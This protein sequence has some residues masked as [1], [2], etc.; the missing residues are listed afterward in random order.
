M[1][2]NR[3][4]AGY[5]RWLLLAAV[6]SLLLLVA[7]AFAEAA[8]EVYPDKASYYPNQDIYLII[9]GPGDS[10]FVV[11][12]LN[13]LGSVV[14]EKSGRTTSSG[15]SYLSYGGFSSE[16]SYEIRLIVDGNV[17]AVSSFIVAR[18]GAVIT[19]TSQQAI[20]TTTATTGTVTTITVTTSFISPTTPTT[21]VVTTGGGG[22]TSVPPNPTI[23]TLIDYNGLPAIVERVEVDGAEAIPARVTWG[24]LSIVDSPASI[25]KCAAG[26]CSL[27][28]GS[29][30]ARFIDSAGRQQN[31]TDVVDFGWRTDRFRLSWLNRSADISVFMVYNGVRYSVEEIRALF[32]SVR[33]NALVRDDTESYKYALNISGIPQELAGGLAYV[34]FELKPAA[35]MGQ[36]SMRAD[37]NGFIVLNDEL[38]LGFSDLL[39]SNYSVSFVN[40]STVLIGGVRNKTSLFLDP[41]IQLQT[42]G[43]RNLRDTWVWGNAVDT[44]YG[45][46]TTMLLQDRASRRGRIHI[47][48]NISAVPSSVSVRDARL[49]L[50]LSTDGN[51]LSGSAYHV[52]DHTWDGQTEA[53]ITWNNQVC[54][55]GFDDSADC[56][57]TAE[58]TQATTAVG[59]VC[60]NVT[61]M[62]NVEYNSGD[63]NLSIVVRS[64]ETATLTADQFCTKE[65][66]AAPC[67]TAQRPYLNVTYTDGTTPKYSN[68]L[69]SPSGNPTYGNA[70]QCNATWTDNV[71]LSRVYFR[72]NYSGSWANYTASSSGS[73]YYYSIPS[74][75]LSGGE[76]VGWNYWANDTANNWNKSMSTQSFTVQKATPTMTLLLNGTN[77]DENYMRNT[78]ANLAA[79]LSVSGKTVEIWANFSGS[80]ARRATGASPLTNITK[81]NY[82]YS[83]YIVKANFSGDLNYTAAS[84]SHNLTVSPDP[85]PPNITA[86]SPINLTYGLGYLVTIRANVTDNV[87]VDT[88]RLNITPPGGAAE[89]HSM[90]NSTPAVFTY[91]FRVWKTGDYY[92]KIIANDTTGNTAEYDPYVYVR[93]RAVVGVSTLSETYGLNADVNLTSASTA[94]FSDQESGTITKRASTTSVYSNTRGLLAYGESGVNTPTY[95]LWNTTSGAWTTAASAVSIGTPLEYASVLCSNK[96][97]ECALLT[98]DTLEDV[99]VQFRSRIQDTLCWNNGSACNQVREVETV[100]PALAGVKQAG[101]A[102][103]NVS[104]RLL[105][106]WA[107]DA[108]SEL[109]YRVWNGTHF[110]SEG[111]FTF[112]AVIGT[113]EWIDV[114]HEPGTNRIAVAAAGSDNEGAVVIW[115]GTA[116]ESGCQSAIVAGLSASERQKVDCAF[117]QLT[118]DL[119]CGFGI[120][121]TTEFIYV[122]KPFGSCVYTQTQTTDQAERS[123]FID[124]S[125]RAGSDIILIVHIADS[126]DDMEA[127]AW[128]GTALSTTLATE[129]STA[130]LQTGDYRVDTACARGADVCKLVYGDFSGT[131]L[132]QMNYVPSTDTWSSVADWT[133]TP[134]F[135]DVEE[136]IKCYPY[137]V[138]SKIMCVIEDTADDLWAKIY[139]VSSSTWYNTEGGAALDSTTSVA[140]VINFD[141][142]WLKIISSA[143]DNDSSTEYTTYGNVISSGVGD[144][145]AIKATVYVSYYNKTAS[146]RRGNNAPD[147]QLELYDG[148]SWI[149][150]GSFSVNSSGNFSVYSANQSVLAAWAT[151]SNSDLRLRGIN[152][153][154]YNYS[155]RDEIR[156]TGVWT[157]VFNGSTLVNAGSKNISSYLIMTVE[158]NSS[159][160][161]SHVATV[162]NDTG[163]STMRNLTPGSYFDLASLWNPTHWNTAS[164]PA[165]YYRVHAYMAASNGSVLVGDDGRAIDGTHTFLLSVYG[166]ISAT[167]QTVGY[168]QRVSLSAEA[169]DPTTD[170]VYAYVARP[171]EAYTAYQMT[172]GSGSIYYYN[173][174][175]TWR[176][177]NYSYYIWSNNSA[178]LISTSTTHLFYVRA[179]VSIGVKTVNDSYGPYQDV[180]LGSSSLFSPEWWNPLW[181]YRKQVNITNVGSAALTDFAAY[182]NIS[183]AAGMQ[184]DY[185]DLRFVVNSTVLD[186]EIENYTAANVHVW[187]KIPTLSTGKTTIYMYY[188]NSAASA[189]EDPAAVWDS[190][191]KGVW[192]L[193]EGG[194]SA[195]IDST[196]NS[197]NL[198]P[199]GGVRHITSG[200]A[201]GADMFDGV[202][203]YSESVNNINISGNTAR[204]VTFWLRINDTT[205]C[206]LVGWGQDGN[207]MHYEIGV[208]NDHWFLWGWG[209]GND[210]DTTVHPTTGVWVYHAIVYD[211]TTVRWYVNGTQLGTGFTHAYNTVDT[212]LYVAIEDDIGSIE[213][214]NGTL[215]EIRISNTARS[216]GWINQTRQLVEKQSSFV[217]F[218]SA[219][220]YEVE[221]KASNVG[222][223]NVSGYLEMRVQRYSGGSW[224]N[225]EAAF[226]N[227]R[228]PPQTRRNITV[229]DALALDSIWN[230]AGWNTSLNPSGLYRAYVRL[231]SPLGNALVND[232]GSAIAGWYNFTIVSSYMQLSRVEHE[233]N[234]TASLDEYETGDNIAWVNITAI[235]RNTT[236]VNASITLNVLNSAKA[237][238]SWGPLTETKYCGNLAVNA[239]CERKFDNSTVGYPIPVNATAGSYRFYWNVTMASKSG[240]SRNNNSLYFRLHN[241][242][243]NTSSTLAPTKIFQNKSAIYNFTLTNPWSKNLTAISVEVNCPTVAGLT[244]RCVGTALSYCSSSSLAAGASLTFSFNISTN[245]TPADDYTINATLN[246][247]NP[248]LE[249]RSW[250]QLRNQVLRVRIPGQFVIISTS[251]TNMTRNG[252][253]TLKGYSNNTLGSAMHNVYLNWTLPVG[254]TNLS[255]SRSVFDSTQDANEILWNNITAY[256]DT[257]SSLGPQTVELRS[258]SAEGYEDWDTRTIIVYAR[259]YITNLHPNSTDPSRGEAVMLTGQLTLDNGTILPYKNVSMY[260]VTAGVPIGYDETDNLGWFYI[261]YTIPSGA[262]LGNHTLNASFGGALSSYYLKTFNTTKINVH[263]KPTITSVSDSPDPQGYSYRIT[264]RANVTD[265][266][267]VRTVRV[268]VTPPS[269]SQT[270]YTMTNYSA[271][272]YTYNY[273][274]TWVWGN[275]SYYVWANDSA[276]KISQSSTY[277]FHVRSNATIQIFTVKSAYGPMETV[278]LTTCSAG[279]WTDTFTDSS[280]IDSSAS[281]NY[282]VTGG[283]VRIASASYT[284]AYDFASCTTGTDCWAWD[285]DTDAAPPEGAPNSE[286][287]AT[288]ANYASITVS[289]GTRWALVDPGLGDYAW[290]RSQ[291]RIVENRSKILRINFTAKGYGSAT[292]NSRIYVCNLT[293][294]GVALPNCDAWIQVVEKEVTINPPDTTVTGSISSGFS[295]IVS[296]SGYIYWA[297]GLIST[298]EYLS[299]D[300]VKL[301]VTYSGYKSSGNITSTA[302]TPPNLANWGK[303]QVSDSLLSSTNMTFAVLNTADNSVLC[304]LTSAQAVAGFNISSCAARASSIKLRANM[305]TTNVSKTP[306]LLSWNVTWNNGSC[307]ANLGATNIT[308]YLLL[309]VQRYSGGSWMD[310]ASNNPVVSDSSARAFSRHTS[311]ALKPIWNGVGEGDGW[312]TSKEP[313]GMY[314]VY[315]ALRDP[316]GNLL[317]NDDGSFVYDTHNFNITNPA[318]IIQLRQIR[319]YDVT[320]TSSKKT[321]KMYLMGGGLN[322]TFTLFTNRTYRAEVIVWNNAS[323]TAAWT[324]SSSDVIFHSGLNSSWGVNASGEI[325]YANSTKNFTGGAWS[326]GKITWNTSKGGTLGINQNMTFYYIFNITS[327]ASKDYS[328]HFM[329]NDTMFTREDSSTYHVVLSEDQPPRLYNF[330]YDVTRDLIHRGESLVVY[331]RWNE[332]IAQARAEYNSTSATLQNHTITLPV[333]NPQYWTNHTIAANTSWKLGNHEVKIYAA[334]LNGNLNNT[335]GYLP[336]D[337]WG[338]SSVPSSALSS[339]TITNGSAVSMR[340]RVTSDNGSAL[341]N[342]NVSFYNS[343]SRLGS[344]LTNSTGWA[345][346]TFRDYSLGYENIKCNITNNTAIYHHITANNYGTQTLRTIETKAPWY[347]NATQN[348][349]KVHRGERISLSAYWYDNYRLDYAWLESN[350]TGTF[351]NN[352]LAASQ[353]LNV[354]QMRVY[355]NVTMPVTS[356]LGRMGWRIWAND[357]SSNINKT[358]PRNYTYIW[359]YAIINASSLA[360]TPIYVNTYTTMWCR[361]VDY[362]NGSAIS[363]YNVSFYSNATG[364]M[365]KNVTNSTGWAKWR[366]NDTILGL[367]KITCNIS[368]YP[369]KYYDPGTPSSAS[370]VVRAA[371]PGSDTTAPSATIYALNDTIVTKGERLKIYAKWTENI[372]NA[373]VRFNSTSST[374]RSY[375]PGTISGQWTNHSIVTNSSWTVGIHYSKLNA[376]DVWGNWNN[377]LAYLTF[378]VYGR[379]K[380]AWYSPTTTQ[381]RGIIPLRC[382]VYDKDNNVGIGSYSVNFYN[383]SWDYLGTAATNSSGIASYSWNA[384][385]KSV[386]TKTFYCTIVSSGYYNTTAADD[387]T[388]GTFDLYGRLN[389]TIDL[390]A[391]KTAFY[392][393]K[394]VTLNSTTRD[395]LKVVVTPDTARWYDGAT[396]IAATE[397]ASWAIPVAHATGRTTIVFNA[398]KSY[399]SLSKKN[400]TIYVWGYSNVTWITPLGGNFSAG[401]TVS[402][403]CRVRDVNSSSG[404]LNYPVRFYYKNSTESSYHYL[405]VR[406]TNSTGYAVYGWNTVGLPTGNYTARCNITNNATLYYNATVR[407]SGNTTIRLTAAAARL[408]VHL[409]LPPTL[410]GDGSATYD[411][412]YKVGRNRTFVLKANVTCRNAVCGNVQGTVR[413]NVTANPDTALGTS[414]ATPFYIAGALP[415]NPTSCS[416]NPLVVNESC[417]LNWTINA[418]G[419]LGSVWKLDVLFDGASALSNQTNYTRIRITKVLI[420]HLSTNNIDWGS[421]DPQTTCNPGVNNGSFVNISLDANSN[422]ADGIYLR[423]TDLTNS[424][425]SIGIGNVTWA[426]VNLC[427]NGYNLNSTWAKMR[428]FTASGTSQP[429][430][431]WIDIPAVPALR[432]HGYTYVMAN[433]SSSG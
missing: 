160:S 337:V 142:D 127:V 144:A 298:S 288:A 292:A 123:N 280:K 245:N 33:L 404:I 92:Y 415:S 331:A 370:Q 264:L 129:P 367:Q 28:A 105:I 182:L 65:G 82:P 106:V 75:Q 192:H 320:D 15:N 279:S 334:D 56:N 342:Y 389:A 154:Y 398:T 344:N 21:T 120:D 18:P 224:V 289:G 77:G 363:A 302:V 174:S 138:D 55:I 272:I 121:S 290:I 205:R 161:W 175:N 375:T 135:S 312:N 202:N 45:G 54:A 164:N 403:T 148:S 273:S 253:G 195:R 66:A 352:S 62:F 185:D 277:Y 255:G 285:V 179:S 31:F 381:Y 317:Q 103:E 361:V 136:A 1:D 44:N 261:Y 427:T 210:W 378:A 170:K 177:G 145:A 307:I 395:E 241:V 196:S 388:S 323:S 346:F 107:G 93:G 117:E 51:T 373:S 163:T 230:P 42:A 360:P 197:N 191:Y 286:T 140:G 217:A 243:D 149:L 24:G 362:N 414:Y 156:W 215:D 422:D 333:P 392:K 7:L 40:E 97:E 84:A 19:T 58:S 134:A 212:D 423:G 390:P 225:F 385:S 23:T 124:V 168:G 208:R 303:V 50:Y 399:Y 98:T 104:G 329:L 2:K 131:D 64:P 402:L 91:S 4:F 57:L 401:G 222:S 109:E 252:N 424:S 228:L 193:A 35:G 313:I 366:F 167:P 10:N 293:D 206:G 94:S 70:V 133:P 274:A 343:T 419:A 326:G 412:G 213:Y 74:S 379:S 247:T 250:P 158:K 101:M 328:V 39:R 204:T 233:N 330:I 12:V 281:S 229:G 275:Y 236:A 400:V 341:N 235:N 86:V 251:P 314:R 47:M 83:R 159:G 263:D 165:G 60:W 32:P 194:T 372:T 150:V 386:G 11:Q 146:T 421:R 257:T 17:K 37:G 110:S 336:F 425:Y 315:A 199:N 405:G 200:K 237:K 384:T 283:E 6:L 14:S 284:K 128:R 299:V 173:Y 49:C 198:T 226:V 207:S 26:S 171:G 429:A 76:K 122:T 36:Q 347:V 59:W 188:G 184:G 220:A 116:F 67:N 69:Q 305:V 162:L 73:V 359:G 48:F 151:A 268:C 297:W 178:G 355:F 112:T 377:T 80:M 169:L 3:R 53:S 46:D 310:V 306:R 143:S 369:A 416:G 339:Y 240:T 85:D 408:E 203:D 304:S 126:G 282:N 71:A 153:D 139:N 409:V 309:K 345:R 34:G 183:A 338:W 223:T 9:S 351:L 406:A 81:L 27:T 102:Y 332:A 396:Q 209:G 216:L 391:N 41:T 397:D 218:S 141:F 265:L 311:T 262:A 335:L 364:Y 356:R 300:Y 353:L 176:W 38:A 5:G 357:T 276:G 78:S 426:K 108:N 214:M 428:N 244:C 157:K 89:L 327:N 383:S 417:V 125:P 374:I 115:N 52:K 431:F 318:Y 96:R 287:A 95:R 227:D 413:Y 324:V 278:N 234:V 296:S 181:G 239:S 376:S 350:Q 29:G 301:D 349:S 266:E 394:T 316:S 295:D 232:D 130:N 242:R 61:K 100:T 13:P 219:E 271:N 166:D 354:S 231:V 246:Y 432:Y 79:V 25:K 270:C 269:S 256:A 365:G 137:P 410:P 325:W 368:S 72:S 155:I 16:G 358:N 430:Y 147:L 380:V 294:N 267:G 258:D 189:G 238:I 291:M 322:S 387:D 99:N 190:S 211:G 186:Y 321:D 260:D 87:R 371:L 20:T 118:G 22:T 308:G 90:T 340:C 114:E 319:L 43:S 8:F 187:V 411:V 172:K 393:G 111:S 119:F 433:T 221:S 88:V 248:G 63:R 254:W 420:I 382:R 30:S 418:T 132:D 348:T 152:F 113:I 407:K 180:N 68:I 201:D 259:T 249:E